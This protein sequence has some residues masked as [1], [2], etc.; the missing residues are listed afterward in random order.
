MR[1]L[2]QIIIREFLR[3][4]KRPAAWV[5]L[6]VIPT[7]IF[8][9]L[10]AIYEEGAIESVPI[11]ILDLDHSDL[12]RKVISNV[13]ASPKL[14]II[15]FLNSNNSIDTVFFDISFHLRKF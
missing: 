14:N 2:L 9:Y 12:S 1:I 8:F 6:L 4:K 13:E 7:G 15:K 10:G 11:A 3:L 5:L